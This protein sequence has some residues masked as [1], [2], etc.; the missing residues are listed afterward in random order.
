MNIEIVNDDMTRVRA[1]V[2]V[3]AASARMRE[4]D[5]NGAIH[6]VGGPQILDTSQELFER[7]RQRC[8]HALSSRLRALAH[9]PILGL[10]VESVL[11]AI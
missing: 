5:V 9:R 6:R 3:N 4:E 1:D 10:Y 8:F 11:P 2:I 7:Q